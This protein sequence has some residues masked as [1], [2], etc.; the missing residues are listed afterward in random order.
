[1]EVIMQKNYVTES[2]IDLEDDIYDALN[3][4]GFHILSNNLAI[5]VTVEIV[6]ND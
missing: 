1:M 5:K 3:D 6:E 2:L 4:K